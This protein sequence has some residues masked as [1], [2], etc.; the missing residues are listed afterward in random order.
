MKLTG[1]YHSH[2]IYSSFPK[3]S[4]KHAKGTIRENA[5]AALEQGLKVLAITEHGPSHYIYG[6]N[7][8]LIPKMRKEIDELNKEF[9]P[10][11]L[12]ILLGLESNIIGLDGTID[13]TDDI[14]QYL[15]FLIMGYHYGAMPKDIKSFYGLYLLQSFSKVT[16]L[17]KSK[18]K[19]V[20]TEAFLN[21]MNKNK[22]DMISHPGSKAPIDIIKIGRLA[23]KRDIAL[24]IST[25]HD[26]LS[27]LNIKKIKDFNI[28][29]ML[30]SDAHKPE[31]IGNISKGYQRAIDAGLDF[32]KIWNMSVED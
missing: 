17:F 29:F 9:R 32:N 25:K 30:N 13:A 14:I 10:K 1:D 3:P 21:A 28:R 31:D 8:K 2:T 11:G 18:A 12:N 4:K 20:M 7:K 26:E 6:V 5:Q 27:V 22:L 15:D 16:G 24:E 19:N 23:E